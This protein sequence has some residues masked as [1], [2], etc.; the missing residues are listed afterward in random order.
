MTK[1]RLC[2]LA[3]AVGCLSRLDDWLMD[4]DLV[5][6]VIFGQ[7]ILFYVAIH[8]LFH[9]YDDLFG[10]CNAVD[11]PGLNLYMLLA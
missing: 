2:P 10:I 6:T 4:R 8:L 5:G 9:R 1:R 11:S 7:K 3:V